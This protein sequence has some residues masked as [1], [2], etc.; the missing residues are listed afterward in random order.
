MLPYAIKTLTGSVELIRMINRLGHGVSYT[1]VEELETALCIQKL[2]S[3]TDESVPMPEQIQ[4]LIPTTLAWDNIDRLE[5]T[6]S[7]GG[8]SHRVNGIAV[9][10]TVYGPHPPRKTLHKPVVKK[11]TLDADPIILPPYNAGERVGPPS[12]L[13]IA[14]DNRKVVEQAQKKN[15][16]WILARLHAASSQENPVAGWTGFNITTRDNEDVS[17]NTVA[18]L[19]TINAPATE[20]STIHEVLIRSQIMNTLEL[21]S[22]VVVCDQAT[23]AKAVEILWKHKDKFSHIV[24]IL[25]AF[26]T[27]CTLMAIIGKRV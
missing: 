22:I 24:P 26:H 18:Y 3:H 21:K 25:G 5:E 17:Q 11:R 1:Q 10:P 6:L 16:I 9:Q 23:Y 20:M 27:I 12:R 8:T 19:P 2:E 4:P 14:L 7:G 13:H 15:L